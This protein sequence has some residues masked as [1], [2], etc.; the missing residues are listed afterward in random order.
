MTTFLDTFFETTKGETNATRSRVLLRHV[1][2][3]K[4]AEEDEA[5]LLVAAQTFATLAVA[6][7]LEELVRAVEISAN[8][9]PRRS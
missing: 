4:H 3:G 6:E 8:V 5:V 7:H 2:D 9:Q 1:A